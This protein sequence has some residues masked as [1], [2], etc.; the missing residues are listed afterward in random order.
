[1][2]SGEL[3]AVTNQSEPEFSLARMPLPP[4]G[5][6]H[7][8]CDA[9]APARADTRLLSC[10]VLAGHLVL[11]MRRDGAAML[12]IADH[13]ARN[14]RVVRSSLEAGTIRI[15]HAEE[16]DRPSLTIAEESLIEP[17]VFSRL[18]LD[19]GDREQLLRLDVPGYDPSRYRTERRAALARDGALIPVTLACRRDIQLDGSA[20]CLLY[21]YGAY[22]EAIEPTFTRGL[23]S[24]LDRGVVYAIAHIRGGGER[25]RDW[26]RQGMLRSKP[27]TFCDFIDV[28]DWLAGNQGEPLVD[29]ARIAS[30]GGS[31]GGL[32]QGAV[33]SMRP[34]RWRAVVAEV[35][36]VDCVNTMLDE[37]LPLTI[38]EWD[39]WGDP[40]DP[41]DYACMR[42]Y[43]PYENAPSGSRPALL[44]T[45]AV[46]DVRVG[47]HE[48]AK[49]VA[50]LRATDE[51]GAALLFRPE[52][53]VASHGGPSGR[54]AQ[55]AYEAEVLA[56]ILDAFGI[57][58]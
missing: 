35:P 23:A 45:G 6:S 21:G 15:E 17:T 28:A 31:A 53:G 38:T 26:W 48:P 57:R 46:N 19:T 22:E 51:T 29:G 36:F 55:F 52:L 8:E 10:H 32:L 27:T 5:W 50:R 14:V 2:R 47:V 43:S 9:I 40:R 42:G 25:G 41:A 16:Y 11:T 49:W 12:A 20:A 24:L 30:R 37:S 56:F 39:E 1:V 3:V 34:D 13:E 54:S 44:V 18:N 7:V 58:E 33:F 4:A